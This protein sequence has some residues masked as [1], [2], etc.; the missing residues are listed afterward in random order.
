MAKEKKE[1]KSESFI[2]S[3]LKTMIIAS[4]ISSGVGYGGYQFKDNPIIAVLI[5]LLTGKT[6]LGDGDLAKT[7]MAGVGDMEKK[8]RDFSEEGSF[9]VTLTEISL[10]PATLAGEK[11]PEIRAVVVRYDDNGDRQVMWQSKNAKVHRPNGETGAVLASFEATPFELRW[12]PGDRLVVEVWTRKMLR[13]VKLFERADASKDTFPLAPGDYPLKLVAN[14][15]KSES[16]R[17]NNLTVDAK[18][19]GLEDAPPRRV[20]RNDTAGISE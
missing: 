3:K 1:Q 17:L 15:V 13:G 12:R 20:A 11:S 18:R 6:S 14:G 16:P 19:K 10:D 5:N 4:L 9:D 2:Y 8:S 7:I